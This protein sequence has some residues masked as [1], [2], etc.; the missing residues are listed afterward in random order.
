VVISEIKLKQNNI[1]SV[2]F[3]DVKTLFLTKPVTV[4]WKPV[5]YR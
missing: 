1:V 3:R 2:L 4:L 5:I